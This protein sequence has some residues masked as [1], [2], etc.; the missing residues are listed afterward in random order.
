MIRHRIAVRDGALILA[1]TLVALYC[2]YVVDI[3]ENEGLGGVRESQIEVDEALLIG[4]VLALV[5]LVYG[6]RQYF[7]QKREMARRIAAEHHIRELAY[8]DGLTGLANR[9]QYEEALAAA[10]ASPPR[11]AG[12][13]AVFLLDLNGF[14][15]VN[16]LHGHGVGDEL[17]I[18]VA[19][20]LLS[21]VR[22]GDL[23]ARFGGDEFAVLAMHLAGPEAATNIALRIVEVLDSPISGGG[24]LHRVGVGIGIAL[25]PA[26][27]STTQEA[28]RMADVALYRAKAER[29]STLRFFAPGMDVRLQ[30]RAAMELALR[31]AMDAGHIEARYQPT[32]NLKTRAVIGFEVLPRW[33]DP[34][35]GEIALERFIAIAEE[36]GVI[37]VLAE[38][39]L[40]QACEDARQWPPYVKIA[41]DI[42]PSQ[43]KDQFLPERIMRILSET[44]VAPDRLE[45]EITES[46][47]V[48]DMDNAQVVLGA[49]RNA[50][51][52]IALD[53]FGTGYSSLY[54]LRNFKLDK[55]KI[56]RSFI[57]A[58]ASEHE[59]ACIVSA[60]V[61]L[62]HGLGLTIA[63]EGIELV[64]QERSL[65]GTGC[66]QGQ[67]NLFGAPINAEQAERLFLHDEL[68]D[69]PVQA[70]RL[71]S[72][73]N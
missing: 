24:A 16:D 68:E 3:F 1:G 8:Q 18:V 38:R 57:Q 48:A 32:V 11:A 56:D 70:A 54:H 47:L 19:Q 20:R 73:H 23:V 64:D 52:R 5:L 65:I 50:G 30:E 12:A 49:L 60:L 13:H 34:Q 26:D 45:I 59:S 42:Y 9:R 43:L 7:A 33:L 36:I 72:L 69:T 37:H 58:M 41:V 61:G 27:A 53:N 28:L 10:I 29:R 62:G 17:L 71:P 40:R 44:G 63:A 51:V 46:A 22:D 67:G 35:L 25:I 14:K 31:T 55:V 4:A 21:A 39:I 15:K 2:A 6:A 66:E